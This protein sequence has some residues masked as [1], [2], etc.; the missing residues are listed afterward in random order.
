[1]WISKEK[2]YKIASRCNTKLLRF[3]ES[4]PVIVGNPV[5]FATRWIFALGVEIFKNYHTKQKA[6]RL[7]PPNVKI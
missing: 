6:R 5:I 1:M 7:L 4:N 2:Y 3:N